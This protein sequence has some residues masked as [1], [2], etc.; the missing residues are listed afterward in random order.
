MHACEQ[1]VLDLIQGQC[2]YDI[3]EKYKSACSVVS[4]CLLPVSL[5]FSALSM[6]D[7]LPFASTLVLTLAVALLRTVRA[8]STE[9]C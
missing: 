8:T 2:L 9:S 3:H 1:D 6:T 7:A 5:V 4:A